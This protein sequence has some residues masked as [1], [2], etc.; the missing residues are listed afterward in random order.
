M[1]SWHDLE[2]RNFLVG[3]GLGRLNKFVFVKC[4]KRQPA[5]MVSVSTGKVRNAVV[6]KY[7]AS[8]SPSTKNMHPRAFEIPAQLPMGDSNMEHSPREAENRI[9]LT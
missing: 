2:N 6:S 1:G 3:V 7:S 9:C 5:Q 4:L 8:W